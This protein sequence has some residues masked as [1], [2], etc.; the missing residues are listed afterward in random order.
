MS[1]QFNPK[2][3]LKKASDKAAIS[4]TS[5]IMVHSVTIPKK[6]EEV[7]RYLIY[8]IAPAFLLTGTIYTTS[9]L[10][11]S[12]N[13][14]LLAIGTYKMMHLNI[15]FDLN[16]F[17]GDN[18]VKGIKPELLVFYRFTAI[19][20]LPVRIVIL[21]FTIA[22]LRQQNA[23]RGLERLQKSLQYHQGSEAAQIMKTIQFFEAILRLPLRVLAWELVPSITVF[24]SWHNVVT[25]GLFYLVHFGEEGFWNNIC[26][27]WR[28][29][30]K[31]MTGREGARMVDGEGLCCGTER[32]RREADGMVPA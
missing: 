13:T 12:I 23:G 30:K 6:K 16:E 3:G 27:V 11:R 22:W 31:M 19:P 18:C 29:F 9:S 17:F 20:T 15:G 25:M 2:P 32:S 4:T 1:A 21:S 5:A 10:W 24:C 8:S 28:T 7:Y 26:G 14:I